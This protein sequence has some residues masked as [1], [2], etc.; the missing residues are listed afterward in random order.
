MELKE[1]VTETLVQIQEGIQ[2]A[3]DKCQAGKLV[4][5]INPV[6]GDPAD[7]GKDHIRIVE[8]DVAVTVATKKAGKAGAKL[9]VVAVELGGDASKSVE[10]STVSHVKFSV[11]IVPA[12]QLIPKRR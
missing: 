2:S 6:W 12:V 10:Q 8:F 5:V 3:I 7:I 9:R 1:F 11:P 4:G